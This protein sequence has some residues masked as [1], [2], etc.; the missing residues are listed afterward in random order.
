MVHHATPAAACQLNVARCERAAR[1]RI[2][3]H[4]R[5]FAPLQVSSLTH[6]NFDTINSVMPETGAKV[7]A[8]IAVLSTGAD[9]RCNAMVRLLTRLGFSVRDGRKQGHKVVTH[10]GLAA[11]T[12]AAFSCGHGRNPQVKRVYVAS[13]RSLLASYADDLQKWSGGQR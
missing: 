3:A 8:A 5:R 13:I 6:A 1:T 9:I 10:P 11:F 2:C 4:R 7:H 12:S